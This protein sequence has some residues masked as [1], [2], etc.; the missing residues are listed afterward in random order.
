MDVHG[1]HHEKRPAG[2]HA[3]QGKH[4]EEQPHG[5]RREGAGR[6]RRD[7]RRLCFVTGPTPQYDAEP[8]RDEDQRDQRDQDH[9]GRAV[10]QHRLRGIAGID[11]TEGRF[12]GWKG[13]EDL[14]GVRVVVFDHGCRRD[15]VGSVGLAAELVGI[16]D[17]GLEREAA[18]V[19][20]G[21]LDAAIDHRAGCFLPEPCAVFLDPRVSD[22]SAGHHSQ[23]EKHEAEQHLEAG[24]A[25]TTMI[26]VQI[27]PLHRP[28]LFRPHV[29]S[30]SYHKQGNE[31]MG[32][33]VICGLVLEAKP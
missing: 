12:P 15:T 21:F 6:S 23:S 31:R 17:A 10:T 9:P 19:V 18:L 32:I 20:G 14:L 27:L 24:E 22:D 8:D 13:V 11:V 33:R 7:R 2:T 4:A 25:V 5:P 28:L 1:R 29:S 3:D 26:H 30:S 16:P